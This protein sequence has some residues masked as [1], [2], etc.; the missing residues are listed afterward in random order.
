MPCSGAFHPSLEVVERDRNSE[1][2]AGEYRRESDSV[3]KMC[4]E[5]SNTVLLIYQKRKHSI[6]LKDL[7][8]GHLDSEW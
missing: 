1:R 3:H 8:Q 4:P 2:V 6:V 7:S 5:Q